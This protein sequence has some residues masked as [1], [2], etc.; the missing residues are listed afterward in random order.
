MWKVNAL[1]LRHKVYTSLYF[2]KTLT[3][4]SKE[5]SLIPVLKKHCKRC[6]ASDHAELRLQFFQHSGERKF[7]SKTFSQIA[8][9]QQNISNY[10]DFHKIV[11]CCI[12]FLVYKHIFPQNIID[13][14]KSVNRREILINVSSIWHL[15]NMADL[16]TLWETLSQIAM[17]RY[18]F[19]TNR[20]TLYTQL[21][22]TEIPYSHIS[23][24]EIRFEISIRVSLLFLSRKKNIFYRLYTKL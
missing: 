22:R 9:V 5:L 10:A 8:K 1:A 3:R 15:S 6:N 12:F 11:L 13:S 24:Q 14:V 19:A 18:I 21:V 7:L 2:Y 23:I 4:D 17:K 16:T 20:W